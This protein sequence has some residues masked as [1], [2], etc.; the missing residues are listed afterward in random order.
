MQIKEHGSIYVGQYTNLGVMHEPVGVGLQ[1][2]LH[3]CV[4]TS[5][6]Q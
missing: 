3:L 4:V 6:N 2:C 5:L 1:H